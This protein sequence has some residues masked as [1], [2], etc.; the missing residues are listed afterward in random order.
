MH[1]CQYLAFGHVE[2]LA[3]GGGVEV[4]V[5]DLV[6]D[7]EGGGAFGDGQA[8]DFFPRLHDALFVVLAVEVIEPQQFVQGI[9]DGRDLRLARGQR[10]VL[11]GG[12]HGQ[13]S[14][15]GASRLNS[16]MVTVN[17]LPSSIL[18]IR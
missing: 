15:K 9:A 16:G 6:P 1:V 17:C 2:V 18:S 11:V 12:G 14:L 5:E 7:V 3:Q 8:H 4:D 13:L 10:G